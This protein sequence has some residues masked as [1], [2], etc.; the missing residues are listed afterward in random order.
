MIVS[1]KA[2]ILNIQIHFQFLTIRIGTNGKERFK[3]NVPVFPFKE[4][5]LV[6]S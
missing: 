5:V 4:L 2:Y 1:V 3:K 6:E